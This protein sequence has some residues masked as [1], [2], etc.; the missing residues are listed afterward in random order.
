MEPTISLP[1]P[2]SVQVDPD[3]DHCHWRLDEF[4]DF[5]SPGLAPRFHDL[6]TPTAHRLAL[7]LLEQHDDEA[8]TKASGSKTLSGQDA[9]RLHDL[10]EATTACASYD[11]DDAHYA[12]QGDI[13]YINECF[14]AEFVTV[15]LFAVTINGDD[16][17]EG[18]FSDLTC[19]SVFEL[20][21]GHGG[22]RNGWS[23][24]NIT[25]DGT[26]L[27]FVYG[28]D[29]GR[30]TV[31]LVP[32]EWSHH[33]ACYALEDP[34]VSKPAAMDRHLLSCALGLF[35]AD[36]YACDDFNIQSL[37]DVIK[38]LEAHGFSS[39]SDQARFVAAGLARTWQT[40]LVDLIDAARATTDPVVNQTT[41]TAA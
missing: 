14:L 3:A 21:R 35:E 30:S 7:E 8:S 26:N 28:D 37:D 23:S 20:L 4:V 13:D 1:A 15:P 11:C 40:T 33:E 19:S 17:P 16:E 6:D 24:L 25:W 2:F 10:V 36:Q 12:V 31:D 32:L 22:W 39:L 34:D 29:H 27:E 9:E 41:A 18:L 5:E 38:K